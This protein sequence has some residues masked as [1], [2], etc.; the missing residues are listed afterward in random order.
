MDGVNQSSTLLYNRGLESSFSKVTF[1]ATIFQASALNFFI[2]LQEGFTWSLVPVV[3]GP[4]PQLCKY[5]IALEIF[6]WEPVLMSTLF[7]LYSFE[8]L[9]CL[10]LPMI[11][12]SCTEAWLLVYFISSVSGKHTQNSSQESKMTCLVKC[13]IDTSVSPWPQHMTLTVIHLLGAL[14]NSFQ[15]CLVHGQDQKP[16]F[17]PG[18]LSLTMLSTI[19]HCSSVIK[20]PAARL[21]VP[22][23]VITIPECQP[24]ICIQKK[25]Q[26]QSG[27]PDYKKLLLG[28]HNH[29]VSLTRILQ[30]L[31]FTI[32]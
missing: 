30:T 12:L 25:K 17:K 9:P 4:E 32:S 3:M 5:L 28:Y 29:L 20:G 8:S 26:D 1:P 23:V 15:F 18:L 14:G 11:A 6:V 31:W 21:Q 7:L 27:F 22:L 19:P 24:R 2:P 16:V 10:W 13:L